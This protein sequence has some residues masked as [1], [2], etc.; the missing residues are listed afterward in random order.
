[1]N[2]E[3]GHLVRD[4]SLIADAFKDHY[5]PVPRSLQQAAMQEL[6]GRDEAKVDLQAP[7]PLAKFAAKRRKVRRKIAKA[8]RRRNR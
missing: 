7:T 1:M 8:S 4:R 3:T 2:V 6:R 5:D